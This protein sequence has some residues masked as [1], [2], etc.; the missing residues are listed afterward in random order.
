[1]RQ[2]PLIPLTFTDVCPEPLG[3]KAPRCAGCGHATGDH[4]SGAGWPH[5]PQF[6]VCLVPGCEC[7]EYERDELPTPGATT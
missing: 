4:A 5:P 7:R 3:F 1:M 6:G 2:D